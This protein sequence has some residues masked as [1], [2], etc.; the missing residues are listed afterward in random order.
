MANIVYKSLSSLT[1]IEL[2]Y[3][4]YRKEDLQSNFSLYKDGLSLYNIEGLNNF[5]DVAIN[6]NSIFILTSAINLNS[7]FT[8]TKKINLGRLPGTFLLQPRNSTIYFTKYNP[9]TNSFTKTLTSSSTFYVQPV[10][11]SNEIELFVENKYVQ[12]QAE[13]PYKVILSEKTVSP[14]EIFRQRFEI[15]FV[16]NLITIKTKTDSGY[17]YL[18]FNSDNILR[19]TG[20]ILNETVINDYVFNCLT[21]TPDFLD[22]GFIPTNNW[23]TYYFDVEEEGENK[24]VKIN[25]NFY[26]V[27]TNLLFSLSLELAA[28]KGS[29]VINIADLKTSLTPA[30]GPAPINNAYEK[31]VITTN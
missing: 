12:V 2:K 21:I 31:I 3:Q 7:V 9:T 15:V 25:K 27:P 20:V 30:G 13:Y 29:A 26:P 1:P 24:T 11:N 4:Y 28:E 8:P 10:H 6:K 18:A 16:D 22:R 19:A 23:V 5:Q 14:N 17:R